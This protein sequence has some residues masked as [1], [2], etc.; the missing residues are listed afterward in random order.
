MFVFCF[1][2][3]FCFLLLYDNPSRKRKHGKAESK[4]YSIFGVWMIEE[5]NVC[6][7][8]VFTGFCI[9]DNDPFHNYLCAFVLQ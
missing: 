5:I 2:F 1:A 9:E 4:L 6:L 3:A 8:K 7:T